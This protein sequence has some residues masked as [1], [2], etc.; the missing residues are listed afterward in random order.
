MFNLY[1]T[2]T[3]GSSGRPLTST[4]VN[5]FPRF[6][7]DGDTILYIKRSYEGNAI[8]Y[9]SLKTNQTLLF[10]LGNRKIQSLDW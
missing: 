7:P 1:T 3:D 9:L 5:Q 8:G 6:S 4:G 10:P 2:H